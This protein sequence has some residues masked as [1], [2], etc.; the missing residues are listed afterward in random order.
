MSSAP[1]DNESIRELTP[2]EQALFDRIDKRRMPA[3]IAIIMDG[4]GRWAKQHGYRDRSRGHQ[5]AQDAVRDITEG[6]LQLGIK[7]LTLY[8]FSTE[9]W[10]RPASEVSFL[11]RLFESVL[12]KERHRLGQNGIR[13]LHSGFP[14]RLPES[15]LRAMNETI[16][17]TAG[18]D[19]LLL[20]LALNYGGRA[21]VLQAARAFARDVAAGR[22]SPNDLDEQTFE[23]Y[24]HHP[25][26]PDPD[27]MIR[28]SGELRISNFLI[29]QLAY[30]EIFVTPTLWPD[31][32]RGEL[33]E[34]I[35]SYQSRDRRFGGIG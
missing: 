34:A 26:L 12:L 32:R 28:T 9:N 19:K 11:M 31:F 16:E 1:A 13:L 17:M 22:K 24:M 7:V 8:A 10:S 29:W 21:E 5:A 15:V 35:V 25:E 18:C 2:E 23:S 3:H 6:C 33:F 27:L 20:N 30:S 4:N 14:D